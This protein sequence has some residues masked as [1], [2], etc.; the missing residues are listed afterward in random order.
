MNPDP[1][2]LCVNFTEVVNAQPVITFSNG[3]VEL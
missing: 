3:W 1:T 2:T